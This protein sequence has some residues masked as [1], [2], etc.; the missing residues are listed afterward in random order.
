VN[1]PAFLDVT[2]DFRVFSLTDSFSTAMS[3]ASA[4]TMISSSDSSSFTFSASPLSSSST[5][6]FLE[7]VVNTVCWGSGFGMPFGSEK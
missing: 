3:S 1:I 7:L 6:S 4:S 2:V 5:A